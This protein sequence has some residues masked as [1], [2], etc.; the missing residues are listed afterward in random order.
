MKRAPVKPIQLKQDQIHAIQQAVFQLVET[1]LDPQYFL[2]DVAVEKE[3]GYWYL[4]LYVQ[5]KQG[6]ISIS[7]CETISRSLEPA[8]E[9][10]PQLS[11]F[12][13]NFEVS[14]PGLFRPLKTAREFAFYQGEPVRVTGKPDGKS[15]KNV[16]TLS[17]V[18]E[19][20]LKGF[21]E[22]TQVL[23]LT[24]SNENKDFEVT[25]TPGQAIYLNP[26][27]RF[28]DED[29]AVE[30]ASDDDIENEEAL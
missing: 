16:Q 14:S 30:M 28:P 8:I 29:E 9:A 11:D 26:V 23:T 5:R 22:D 18:A 2:V 20:T 13:Y 24:K 12:A 27:I 25:L 7:E 6:A 17:T 4:R 1:Q 15:K 3:F 21:N 10:L 19:G